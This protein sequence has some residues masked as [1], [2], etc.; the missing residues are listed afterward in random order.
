M[1]DQHARQDGNH[2]PALIAHTGTAGTAETIRVTAN[3]DGSLKTNPV[4]TTG[5]N[6]GTVSIGTAAVELTFTG[7]TQGIL[8]TADQENSNVVYVGASN[9]AVDGANALTRLDAGDVLSVDLNDAS[10]AL[11]AI[12]GTTG[13]KVYKMALT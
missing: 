9:I 10:S 12:G 8:I 3:S 2:F 6:G 13:Q 7:V 5:F 1:A 4:E 11:Y